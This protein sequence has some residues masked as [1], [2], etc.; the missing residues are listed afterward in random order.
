MS[1]TLRVVPNPFF[2]LDDKGRPAGAVML[3]VHE[4]ANRRG[5]VGATQRST[6]RKG[7]DGL[8]QLG[9]VVANYWAPLSDCE[10][11]FDLRT[12]VELPRTSYYVSELLGGR[13]LPADE[14]TANAVGVPWRPHAES[15]RASWEASAAEY[16]ARTGKTLTDP[17][18]K[19]SDP[20]DE[21]GSARKSR[22]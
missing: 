13:L 14:Q 5:L 20:P 12:V 6:A 10:W 16:K 8:E 7:A 4:H 15:W 9:G 3:D 18:A 2:V 17:F 11:D 21:G 22:S 19:P 1:N